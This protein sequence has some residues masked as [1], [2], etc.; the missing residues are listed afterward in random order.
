MKM[1]TENRTML[2]EME[3]EKNYNHKIKYNLLLFKHNK[4]SSTIF[5]IIFLFTSI[6]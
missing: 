5:Y 6:R 1:N 3:T 4:L 2:N